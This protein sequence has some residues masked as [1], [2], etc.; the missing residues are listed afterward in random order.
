MNLVI[1]NSGNL[2]LVVALFMALW[3]DSQSTS[4]VVDSSQLDDFSTCLIKA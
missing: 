4:E 2:E 3:C 1:K